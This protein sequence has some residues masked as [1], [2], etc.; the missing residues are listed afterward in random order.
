[1]QQ[2]IQRR[3]VMNGIYPQSLNNGRLSSGS[4]DMQKVKRAIFTLYIGAVTSGSISAW[5]Q[6]SAND[7]SWTSNDTAGAFSNSGATNVSTTGLV[8]SSSII[9]F[10]VRADQMTPGKR[11][12]RLQVKEV[13][14]S[15]VI[16]AVTAEGGDA[17]FAPASALN[18]T[19]QATNGAKYVVA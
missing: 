11:Y 10:E 7:S 8:T 13:N 3:A 2:L 5:L 9:L 16:L 18:G 15:A 1:M 17:D 12:V 4:V 6:E 14:S 19:Q